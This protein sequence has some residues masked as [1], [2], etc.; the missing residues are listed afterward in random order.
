MPRPV[1][2][3]VYL[4]V[5]GRIGKVRRVFL[6]SSI[7]LG[8]ACSAVTLGGRDGE[9]N[10]EVRCCLYDSSTAGMEMF[11]LA[12]SECMQAVGTYHLHVRV[13]AAGI[14]GVAGGEGSVTSSV[15]MSLH[16][17]FFLRARS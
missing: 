14:G 16:W 5:F 6:L 15:S 9:A 3:M 2:K 10:V 1:P 4:P 13:A 7:P 12:S 11:T 8:T 17:P